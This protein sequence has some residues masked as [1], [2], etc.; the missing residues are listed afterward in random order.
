MMLDHHQS[1]A[2]KLNGF[3]MPLRCRAFRHEPIGRHAGVVLLPS[4]KK[5]GLWCAMCKTA[6]CG[7]GPTLRVP[8]SWLALDMEP[9]EFPRWSE[10]AD[11]T[12]AQI[13]EFSERGRP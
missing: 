2:D 3:Q 12:P 4:N 9:N 7:P 6:I 5:P 1:A 10:I 8:L 11:F 13:A